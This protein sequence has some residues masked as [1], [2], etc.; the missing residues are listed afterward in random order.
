MTHG[1]G[2]YLQGGPERV[3]GH[4][5]G[6]MGGCLVWKS[7]TERRRLLGEGVW[8]VVLGQWVCQTNIA[9]LRLDT[10]SMLS[11]ESPSLCPQCHG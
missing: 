4:S 11:V 9:A 10:V 3:Q 5:S 7:W 1:M 6:N 8:V 2:R